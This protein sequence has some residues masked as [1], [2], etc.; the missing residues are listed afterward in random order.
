MRIHIPCALLATMGVALLAASC[1]SAATP[2]SPG[3]TVAV[4]GATSTSSTAQPAGGHGKVAVFYAGSLADL[5]EQHVGPAF[6]KAAGYRFQGFAGGSDALAN[7]IKGKVR[8]ADVFVSASPKPDLALE[9]QANGGWVTWY[10]TFATSPLLVAYDPHGRFASQL[11]SKPWWQVVTEPGFRLGRT[12]PKL[13]PKGALIVKALDQAAVAHH[14]PALARLAQASSG[15]FPEEELVGRLEAGQLDAGFF[16]SVESAAARP[17]LPTVSI[18]PIRVGATYTITVP[19][20]APDPAGALTFV[21]YLLGAG[22]RPTL[23]SAG[24]HETTPTV[25]GDRAAVPAG[26]HQALSVTG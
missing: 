7:E 4:G 8:R 22:E 25:S 5:M 13:D 11:E 15:V 21:K 1:G 23:A 12:D 2:R 10:A 9:G 3:T 19:R 26:L 16:Y 6:T 18:S 24:L 20:G 17:E 14:D